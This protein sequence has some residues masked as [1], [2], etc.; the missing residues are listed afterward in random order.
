[1]K[2]AAA[3][4]IFDGLGTLASIAIIFACVILVTALVTWIATDAQVSFA[5]IYDTISKAIIVPTSTPSP[6]N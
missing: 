4:G 1:M 5:T 3:A 6:F 2:F